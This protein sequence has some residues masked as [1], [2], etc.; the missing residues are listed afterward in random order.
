MLRACLAFTLLLHGACGALASKP[1]SGGGSGDA[2]AE[3]GAPP[4]AA[5]AAGPV[6]IRPPDEAAAI[7]RAR[8][9]GSGVEFCIGKKTDQCFG[10]EIGRASCR[11]RVLCVV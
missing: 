10:V 5:V 3:P 6:C 9:Y 7:S 1:A 4:G 11:E 2:A 8:T